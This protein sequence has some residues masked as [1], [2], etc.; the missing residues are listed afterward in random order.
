MANKG[1][2]TGVCEEHGDFFMDAKDSPCPTCIC[3]GEDEEDE[4][5]TI[6]LPIPPHITL[7]RGI[8]KRH[9][10][11]VVGPASPRTRKDHG[12]PEHVKDGPCPTCEEEGYA[13]WVEGD[14]SNGREDW[15]LCD[16][17]GDKYWEHNIEE[18]ACLR[19]REWWEKR[20]PRMMATVRHYH[21]RERPYPWPDEICKECFQALLAQ[22]KIQ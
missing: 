20:F 5:G 1:I 12:L 6:R 21:R 2:G 15:I 19:D 17:C 9:G 3:L 16:G 22:E 13:V 7:S 11:F 8:C 10:E 18:E 4:R 14:W